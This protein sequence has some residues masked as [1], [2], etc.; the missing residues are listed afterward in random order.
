MKVANDRI[1][2]R[3]QDVE[4]VGGVELVCP[5]PDSIDGEFERDARGLVVALLFCVTCWVAL[6]VFLLS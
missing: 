6:G 5:V 3:R 4:V 2:D 1:T